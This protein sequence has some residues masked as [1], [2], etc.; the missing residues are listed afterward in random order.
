MTNRRCSYFLPKAILETS[1]V[2]TVDG[3]IDIYKPVYSCDIPNFDWRGSCESVFWDT[4]FLCFRQLRH[5]VHHD[6]LY[7]CSYYID[8]NK[9]QLLGRKSINLDKGNKQILFSSDCRFCLL[10]NLELKGDDCTW[11]HISCV[12]IKHRNGMDFDEFVY[13]K[14]VAIIKYDHFFNMFITVLSANDEDLVIITTGIY[15]YRFSYEYCSKYLDVLHCGISPNG[16]LITGKVRHK[17]DEHIGNQDIRTAIS[18]HNG[19]SLF[20]VT[21]ESGVILYVISQDMFSKLLTLPVAHSFVDLC[22][23]SKFWGSTDI[24]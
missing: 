22:V 13:Y 6:F 18:N 7:L 1:L 2:D 20:I 10:F 8:E 3:E 15:A 17:L 5:S 19:T 9:L 21:E 24:Y 14:D 4:R 16:V 11:I 23:C 12:T